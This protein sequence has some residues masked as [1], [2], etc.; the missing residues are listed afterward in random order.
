MIVSINDGY[1]KVLPKWYARIKME[2]TMTESRS[3]HE[4]NEGELTKSA[5]KCSM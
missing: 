2:L 5:Y 3:E 1:Y 4:P